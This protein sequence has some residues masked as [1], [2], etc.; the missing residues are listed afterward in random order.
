MITILR[1][2]RVG[3]REN[4]AIALCVCGREIAL[5]GFTN[6]CECGLEFNSSG[7]RLAPREQWGEETGEHPADIAR[8][9]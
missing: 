9:P 7:Y 3:R 5:Y 2:E 1:R 8:I 6:T 4:C